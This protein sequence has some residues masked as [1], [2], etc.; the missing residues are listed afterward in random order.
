MEIK[1]YSNVGCT[2]H[3]REWVSHWV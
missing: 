2:E 1:L 3:H